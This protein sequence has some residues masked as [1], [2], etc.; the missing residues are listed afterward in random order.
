MLRIQAQLE[1]GED[2]VAGSQLC[3]DYHLLIGAIALLVFGAQC[4]FRESAV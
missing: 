2:K 4:F 3:T 1:K